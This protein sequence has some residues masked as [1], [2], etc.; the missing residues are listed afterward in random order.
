[1]RENDPMNLES[2]QWEK[3]RT[4]ATLPT[5]V[6]PVAV[7]DVDSG[8]VLMVAYA[9]RDAVRATLEL[10]QAVFWSTSKNELHHKGSTSGDFLDLE[11]IR[12]N[13]EVNSL[14]YR[15]RKRSIG[16]CHLSDREGAPYPTC[17]FRPLSEV[18]V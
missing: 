14:L 16:A 1:M 17:F 7:Q 13:C 18:C 6:L 3:L 10:Q 15:V 2:L 9:N 4:V 11:E 12:V 5:P 8:D